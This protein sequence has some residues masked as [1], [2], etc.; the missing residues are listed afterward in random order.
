MGKGKGKVSESLLTQGRGWIRSR[1]PY[2]SPLP[3]N[4]LETEC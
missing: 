4:D 3:F 2:P 1:S